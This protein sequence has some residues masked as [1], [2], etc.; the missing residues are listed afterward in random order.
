M[1]VFFLKQK[2]IFQHMSEFDGLCVAT[3][4]QG[5]VEGLSLKQGSS[6]FLT[7]SCFSS[8]QTWRGLQVV[9]VTYTHK[10]FL[11]DLNVPTF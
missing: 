7:R 9:L 8:V 4:I 6:L 3:H 11:N 2:F 1:E 10:L 5:T